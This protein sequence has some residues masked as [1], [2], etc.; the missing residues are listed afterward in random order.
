MTAAR[1]GDRPAVELLLAHGADP[2]ARETW[3]GQT[4]LMW[5]AAE[6]HLAATDSLL[7]YGADVGARSDGEFTPLLFAVRAG[8]GA[9]ASALVAAGADIDAA[10]P[11]GHTPLVLAILNGHY[12]LAAELLALGADPEAATPGGTALHHA[13]RWNRYEFTDF[14]RPPPPT[15]GDLDP[16]GLVRVLL[17]AGR[18][19]QRA[20]REAVP[21]APASSTTTGARCRSSGPRR[22]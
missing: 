21:R 15:T 13:V 18:R 1:S 2:N 4:A 14:Y 16:L 9:V 17:A 19:P 12:A 5:A 10:D 11:D 22:S 20:D 3:R 8:D 7:R 6:R